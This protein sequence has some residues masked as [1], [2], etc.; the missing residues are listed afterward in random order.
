MNNTNPYSNNGNHKR[1]ST[2]SQY[3]KTTYSAKIFK[4]ALNAGLTCPNR[5]GTCGNGGC[6]FCSSLGSGEF[7]GDKQ[8]D[9][10]TQFTKGYQFQ[11]NKWPNGK[12]IA[13]FQAYTNT[14]CSL[15]HLQKMLEP[16][17]HHP[18]VVAIALATRADCLDDEKITYLHSQTKHKDI[19]IELGLQSIHD[20]TAALIN[21]GHTFQT[22]VDCVQRL[23]KTDIK[24][25]FI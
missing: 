13:F 2:W 1:Y 14:Y 18:D 11:M 15:T 5:D 16:F 22:F 12:A 21:R 7:A 8:D 24:F 10:L 3:L 17:L 23:H 25:V 19:W 20:D 9:L 6:T 4:V